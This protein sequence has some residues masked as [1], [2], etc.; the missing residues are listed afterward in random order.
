M[1]IAEQNALLWARAEATA[2]TTLAEVEV[3][4]RRNEADFK[5]KLRRTFEG[6]GPEADIEFEK[7]WDV[8][9]E[10]H[11]AETLAAWKELLKRQYQE[12][13]TAAIGSKT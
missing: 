11:I 4:M 6:E 5:K 8:M 10:G 13:C 1:S 3:R 12:R 9:W 7:Q 2:A